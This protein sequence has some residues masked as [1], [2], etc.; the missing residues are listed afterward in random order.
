LLVLF[1]LIRVIR[2]RVFCSHEEVFSVGNWHR[3]AR[4]GALASVSTC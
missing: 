2:G 1:L 4:M 3:S